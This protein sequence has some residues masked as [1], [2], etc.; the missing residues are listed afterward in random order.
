M[1]DEG[2]R[3]RELSAHDLRS[4]R[5]PKPLLSRQALAVFSER[6]VDVYVASGLR[7]ILPRGDGASVWIESGCH[8][9][10][11]AT[12]GQMRDEYRP[13]RQRRAGRI[14]ACAFPGRPCWT[15]CE[16]PAAASRALESGGCMRCRRSPNPTKWRRYQRSAGRSIERSVG[17]SL[18]QSL[19]Y[20]DTCGR[21]RPSAPC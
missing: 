12:A 6:D 21:L 16:P 2:R 1:R 5:G 18:R 4:W 3:H 19:S 15:M 20:R 9:A 7:P 8:D 13:P 14:L 11:A 10:F 17:R